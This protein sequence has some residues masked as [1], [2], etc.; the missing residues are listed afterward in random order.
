MLWTPLRSPCS[1][2]PCPRAHLPLCCPWPP[3]ELLLGHSCPSLAP[4][5]SPKAPHATWPSSSTPTA[6]STISVPT[7]P[8]SLLLAAFPGPNKHLTLE[9]TFLLGCHKG[10]QAT[11]PN[12][13]LLQPPAHIPPGLGC[14]GWHHPPYQARDWSAP[15]P[16]HGPFLSSAISKLFNCSCHPQTVT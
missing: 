12:Q 5:I 13:T 11:S 7:I 8:K 10:S 1:K 6:S 9:G 16:F 4:P 3:Q 14:H 2:N 15:G